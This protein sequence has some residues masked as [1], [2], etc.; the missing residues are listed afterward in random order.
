M[1]A[2]PSYGGASVS[3]ANSP[4]KSPRA[5]TR[6]ILPREFRI[7]TWSTEPVYGF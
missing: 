1:A 3:S 7:S 5:S 4:R 2:W 6:R